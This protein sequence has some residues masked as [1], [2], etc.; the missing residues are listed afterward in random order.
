MK[1]AP[2]FHVYLLGSSEQ[3]GLSAVLTEL[4]LEAT[5]LN[6]QV[7]VLEPAL[8]LIGP[9]HKAPPG[10]SD[11]SLAPPVDAPPS[12]LRELPRVARES[13]V[14]KRPFTGVVDAFLLVMLTVSWAPAGAEGL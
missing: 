12:V 9:G 2:A 14:L 11:I 7:D 8:I 10:Y 6:D 3:P 5:P 1:T 13:V 4:G